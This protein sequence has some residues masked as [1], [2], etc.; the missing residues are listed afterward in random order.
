M[1]TTFWVLAIVGL[2]TGISKFSIG[3]MGIIILPILTIAFPGPEAVAILV[4]MYIATDIM[5]VSSYRSHISWK[6]LLHIIPIAFVGIIVGTYLLTRLDNDSFTTMLG[7]LIISMLIVSIWLDIS[8]SA[9]LQQPIIIQC[10]SFFAG[11]ITTIANAA[12][13][14]ISLLLLEQKLSKESYV[15]TRAWIFMIINVL[16]LLMLMSIGLM[17]IEIAKHSLVAFLPLT[18]GAI[19]GYYLL[20]KLNLNQFKWLIRII[21]MIAAIK[22]LIF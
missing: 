11:I 9:V 8:K 15:S 14:L 12:G 10:I 19:I 6:T 17:N 18:I 13:S 5:A 4:P 22:L 21:A 3:G 20:K 16:K 7:G 1:D 2:V